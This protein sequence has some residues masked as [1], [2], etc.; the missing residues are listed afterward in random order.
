MQVMWTKPAKNDLQ[1]IAEYIAQDNITASLEVVDRLLI[2]GNGLDMFSKRGRLGD[3]RGTFELVVE[4]TT[5]NI[6]YALK[7]KWVYILAVVHQSQQWPPSHN[8]E[9]IILELL[10]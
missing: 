5:C 4:K 3:I 7:G 2:A 9:K 8:K 10:Q 1:G 6:V